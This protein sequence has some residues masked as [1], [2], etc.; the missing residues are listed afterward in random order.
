[1]D[2]QHESHEQFENSRAFTPVYKPAAPLKHSGL[3]ITSFVLS[4]VNIVSFV[5]LTVVIGILIS[6][7]I[8]FTAIADA[9]RNRTIRAERLVPPLRIPAHGHWVTGILIIPYN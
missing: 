5:F 1:M 2:E 7:N 4:L 8:N 6:K 3:G 9:N